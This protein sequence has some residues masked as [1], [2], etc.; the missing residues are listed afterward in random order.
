[1][2]EKGI[3]TKASVYLFLEGGVEQA[4]PLQATEILD[5]GERVVLLNLKPVR[6]ENLRKKSNKKK[7]KRRK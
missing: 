6:E 2:K 4:N 5:L 3:F 7:K 1:M